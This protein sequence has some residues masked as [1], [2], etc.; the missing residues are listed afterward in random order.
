MHVE[1][2][3]NPYQ[4]NEWSSGPDL[5][6]CRY[7]GSVCGHHQRN[8]SEWNEWSSGPVVLTLSHVS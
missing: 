3:R 5:I 2:Q 7:L 1:H 8:P 4:W 6:A